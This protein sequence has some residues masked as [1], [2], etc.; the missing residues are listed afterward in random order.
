MIFDSNLYI[1]QLMS[2]KSA[3]K[4]LSLM[5]VTAGKEDSLDIYCKEND[6]IQI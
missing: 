6:P 1:C 2:E 3:S 5:S 4:V